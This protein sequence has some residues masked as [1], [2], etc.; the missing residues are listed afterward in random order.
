[1]QS[2]NTRYFKIALTISLIIALALFFISFAIGK[3]QFFL[4]LNADAGSI[5]DYFFLIFTYGGDG[6]M[7]IPV[8]LVTLF[9]LKRK[10]V[11]PL[12]VSAFVL[13]TALT[14]VIKTMIIPG[15]LRPIKVITDP[16][17]IHLVQG[18]EIYKT[19]SFPSGHTGTAF[20]F[21]LL[22]CLLINKRWWLIVGL[23][24]ALLVGYSRVYLAQHF[25]LDVAA[26]IIIAIISTTA[27][28]K[29]QEYW[30]RRN[31]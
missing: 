28:L 8:L 9:I 7:W 3:E 12:L 24:Y 13:S 27:A 19:S 22:F 20:C 23:I 14:R 1:M 30:W 11:L 21:Y 16:L 4:L 31:G 18:V 6:L 10:D 25:P 15:V 2:L 29:I 26:G 17:L 5:A